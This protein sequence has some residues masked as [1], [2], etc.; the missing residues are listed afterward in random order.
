MRVMALDL[1]YRSETYCK[2]FA[3]SMNSELTEQEMETKIAGFMKLME[4]SYL[5]DKSEISKKIKEFIF[6]ASMAVSCADGE[7]EE[8]ELKII[9]QILPEDQHTEIMEKIQGWSNEMML[10]AVAEHAEKILP[11]LTYATMCNIV[12]DLV[13]LSVAD[14]DFEGSEH[15][16]LE[17]ICEALTVYPTFIDDVLNSINYQRTAA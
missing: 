1:F 8:A 11:H 14:G 17:K 16:V 9:S 2:H 13:L 6:L 15:Q 12:R 3:T 4:P 5:W 7:M 10:N